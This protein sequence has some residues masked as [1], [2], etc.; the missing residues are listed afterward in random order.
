VARQPLGSNAVRNASGV[1]GA[2]VNELKIGSYVEFAGGKLSLS[3]GGQQ[4][5]VQDVL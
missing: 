5:F 4:P 2:A 1:S 3:A